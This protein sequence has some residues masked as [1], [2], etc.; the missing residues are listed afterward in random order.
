M[1]HDTL[2]TP[3]TNPLYIH[4]I[5]HLL[6][7][8]TLPPPF[9]SKTSHPPLL[10]SMQVLKAVAGDQQSTLETQRNDALATALLSITSVA[11][12]LPESLIEEQTQARFQNMLMDF[13]EQ[14][15]T[16][17]QLQEMSS[18]EK[19]TKYAEISRPNVEKIVTLGLIFRD[20]SEKENLAV[21][22]EEIQQQLDILLA[23][24]NQKKKQQ[25]SPSDQS[26]EGEG[27]GEGE[28]DIP[29]AKEE[30]ENA[31]LRRKVFDFIASHAHITYLAPPPATASSPS[32]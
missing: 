26:G 21:T 9:I 7:D 31:L 2:R 6:R 18:L 29:R 13:K 23:Q 16:A 19:Y 8:T 12:A 28:V 22:P 25:Q 3:S 5:L 15:S 24:A 17:E 10:H 32:S 27:Q 20:I 4:R 14:G 1:M 30:I 11:P